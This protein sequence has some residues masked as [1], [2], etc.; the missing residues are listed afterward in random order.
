[1][2]Q[3]FTVYFIST[4]KEEHKSHN[5]H[6]NWSM[7]LKLSYIVSVRKE[8]FSA[9]TKHKQKMLVNNLEET[10]ISKQLNWG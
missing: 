7:S 5:W 3:T 4:N 10:M 1:M 2:I 8:N 9:F 6:K